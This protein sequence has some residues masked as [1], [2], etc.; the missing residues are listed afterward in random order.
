M[1][2]KPS[3]KSCAIFRK[4]PCNNYPRSKHACA[5]C[6]KFLWNPSL[7]QNSNTQVKQLTFL[8]K[9]ASISNL[10][11]SS[12]LLNSE[13]QRHQSLQATSCTMASFI[14]RNSGTRAQPSAVSSAAQLT[15]LKELK[16]LT[17]LKKKGMLLKC[18]NGPSHFELRDQEARTRASCLIYFREFC[19]VSMD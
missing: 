5:S 12:T 6:T 3:S 14:P 1:V 17:S 16:I 13:M 19:K 15:W 8:T 7:T 11:I 10:Q 18:K 9:S 2:H 4:S